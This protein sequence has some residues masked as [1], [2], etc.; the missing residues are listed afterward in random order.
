MLIIVGSY[1]GMYIYIK[2]IIS[3]L[4]ARGLLALSVIRPSVWSMEVRGC[5]KAFR[6]KQP[7]KNQYQMELS[8]TWVFF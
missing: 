7:F 5:G 6:V 1:T 2:I 4:S 8:G 3:N